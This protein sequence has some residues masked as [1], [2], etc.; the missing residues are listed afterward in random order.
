MWEYDGS[1]PAPRGCG[2]HP[3]ARTT[4]RHTP[5]PWSCPTLPTLLLSAAL[6][7]QDL[8]KDSAPHF[9]KAKKFYDGVA[10]ELVAHG[11]ALDMFVCALDQV[12]Q[13]GDDINVNIVQVLVFPLDQ[14]GHRDEYVYK[15]KMWGVNAGHRVSWTRRGRVGR[16]GC[17]SGGRGRRGYA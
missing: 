6:L 9:R 1:L 11:H 12:G 4:V 13:G 7:P 3:H 14:V 15:R 8:A 5:H 16:V 17:G 10:G 2:W